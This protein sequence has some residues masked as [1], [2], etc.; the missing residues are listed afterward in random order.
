MACPEKSH[1]EPTQKGEHLGFF[2]DLET[3]T[4]SVSVRHTLRLQEKLDIVLNSKYTTAR[5]C[6]S[7]SGTLISMGLAPGLVARLSTRSIYHQINSCQSW[8]REMILT[9]ES[10][11]ELDFW[12][13]VFL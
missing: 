4:F 12:N 2:I 5:K 11:H 9:S 7:I 6:A 13:K 8:D 3:G 1:W 10:R